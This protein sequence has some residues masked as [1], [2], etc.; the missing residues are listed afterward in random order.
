MKS[1]CDV[2]QEEFSRKMADTVAERAIAIAERI[3]LTFCA[4][5]PKYTVPG[6]FATLVCREHDHLQ[7]EEV[8]Q[9]YKK[10]PR[11]HPTPLS[12]MP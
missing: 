10:Y 2:R 9:K 6:S 4:Q 1:H 11:K 5:M 3:V 8:H 7:S 12:F